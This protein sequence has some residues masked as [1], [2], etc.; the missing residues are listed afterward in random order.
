MPQPV[1]SQA[2]N[3]RRQCHSRQPQFEPPPLEQQDVEAEHMQWQ[4]INNAAASRQ[5]NR[6]M[7][8]AE[9][10]RRLRENNEG[11]RE[12]ERRAN[13]LANALATAERMGNFTQF[14]TYTCNEYQH[15][16]PEHIH[17]GIGVNE[18]SQ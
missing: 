4:M 7:A 5:Y 6:Q 14:I 9:R 13:A 10:I 3:R 11:Y 16:R 8:N 18:E 2:E 1:T 17:L 15:N 12:T